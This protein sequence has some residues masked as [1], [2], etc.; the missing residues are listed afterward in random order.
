MIPIWWLGGLGLAAIFAGYFLTMQ[1]DSNTP[2]LDN[3]VLESREV[4]TT[5]GTNL[6]SEASNTENNQTPS[7]LQGNESKASVNTI[8]VSPSSAT[9][10]NN[11]TPSE[12]KTAN[13]KSAKQ[14]KSSNIEDKSS[15]KQKT[16]ANNQTKPITQVDQN[17][18]STPI[19]VG[20]TP[21]N[22]YQVDEE[23]I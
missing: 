15:V 17:S 16:N 13:K 18:S 5:D 2:A 20:S 19:G 10:S 1:G 22:V 3:T 4:Q 12:V 21:S 11:A 9:L 8:V 6:Q 7:S 14:D 23:K